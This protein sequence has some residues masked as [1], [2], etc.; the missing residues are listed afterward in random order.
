MEFEGIVTILGEEEKI[1][2]NEIPKKTFVLEEDTDREYKGSMAVDVFNDKISLLDG[3]AIW[4]KVKVWLNFRSR[5]YNGRYFNSISA[6]RLD[7]MDGGSA[8]PA[9]TDEDLPF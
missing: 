4:D 7:K 6:W 5:E 9:N 2:Q 8:A 3:V 1:G